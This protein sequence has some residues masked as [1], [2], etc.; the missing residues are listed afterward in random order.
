MPNS[1]MAVT[2]D[3]GDE[4]NAHPANKHH[5][6]ARLAR[7]ALARTYGKAVADSGPVLESIAATGSALRLKFTRTAGGLTAR[8]GPLQQ[9][10]AAGPDGKWAWADATIEGESVIVGNAS[11]PS[12]LKGR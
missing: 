2:I 6:G 3:T 8:D 10:A 9:F 11:I 5:V 1:G 4:K 12:P 7:L